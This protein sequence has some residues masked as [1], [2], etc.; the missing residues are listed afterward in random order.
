MGDAGGFEHFLPC[1]RVQPTPTL[2]KQATTVI[3]QSLDSFSLD[4]NRT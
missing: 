2:K 3:N 4:A 1:S